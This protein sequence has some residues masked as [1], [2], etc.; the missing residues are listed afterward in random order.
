MVLPGERREREPPE[1]GWWHKQA[2]L[3]VIKPRGEPL[4]VAEV[5]LKAPMTVEGELPGITRPPV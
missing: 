2:S 4:F 1:Q 3:F 5:S